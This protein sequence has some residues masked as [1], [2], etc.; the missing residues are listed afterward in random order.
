M[1][2]LLR[3]IPNPILLLPTVLV[4]DANLH[5]SLWNPT[6]Y[7][8]HDTAA[9]TLV[10]TMLQWNLYLKSLKGVPTYEAKAGMQS[11]VTIDLVWMNQQ[12]DDLLIACRVDSGDNLNHRSD[13]LAIVTVLTVNR[14]DRTGAAEDQPSAKAWHKVDKAKFTHELKAL[15]S[16]VEISCTPFEIDSQ[17]SPHRYHHSLTR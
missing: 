14:E 16:P 3:T 12:A 15:L 11:G 8:V 13:H 9:D 4:T 1:E 6:A 5:S 10:E 7:Q 2:N 17:L